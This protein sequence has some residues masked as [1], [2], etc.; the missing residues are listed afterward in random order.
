M[1]C[2]IICNMCLSI[3]SAVFIR[4]LTLLPAQLPSPSQRSSCQSL[5]IPPSFLAPLLSFC[6]SDMLWLAQRNDSA[7]HSSRVH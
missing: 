6:H 7:D 1:L 4:W 3:I 2:I 5:S